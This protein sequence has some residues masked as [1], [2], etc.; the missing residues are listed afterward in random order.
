MVNS[1]MSSKFSRT[2]VLRP[3]GSISSIYSLSFSTSPRSSSSTSQPV[4]SPFFSIPFRASFS[5]YRDYILAF[6]PHPRRRSLHPFAPVLKL[7]R[8][9]TIVLHHEYRRH[10]LRI[11]VLIREFICTLLAVHG[12]FRTVTCIILNSVSSIA[13]VVCAVS[14]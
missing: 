9:A 3:S 13:I 2:L 4:S 14:T 6:F 11:L 12:A 5:E 7:G 1:G 10:R 8:R